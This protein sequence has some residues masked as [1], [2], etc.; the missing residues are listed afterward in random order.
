MVFHPFLYK[1]AFET[2]YMKNYASTSDSI[3]ILK[4]SISEYHN[5]IN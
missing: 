3:K 2:T 5:T 1:E 4:L